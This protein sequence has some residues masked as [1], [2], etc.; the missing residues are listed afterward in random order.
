LPVHEKAVLLEITLTKCRNYLKNN[1]IY[2]LDREGLRKKFGKVL[3]GW[4]DS[5]KFF[6]SLQLIMN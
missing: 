3:K 1:R 6:R 5:W 4:R 2:K